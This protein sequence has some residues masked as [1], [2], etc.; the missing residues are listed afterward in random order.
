MA[1]ALR[2]LPEAQALGPATLP[3][4]AIIPSLV[5]GLSVHPSSNNDDA[6]ILMMLTAAIVY[7]VCALCWVL[8]HL[9][10][11]TIRR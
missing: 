1:A 6:M 4:L 5:L 11:S 7:W 2:W 3:S 9:T 10:L 8:S